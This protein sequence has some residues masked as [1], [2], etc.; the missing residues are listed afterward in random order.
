MKHSFYLRDAIHAD[1]EDTIVAVGQKLEVERRELDKWLEYKV[2]Y[3]QQQTA[4]V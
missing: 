1:L 4:L 2:C 3:L